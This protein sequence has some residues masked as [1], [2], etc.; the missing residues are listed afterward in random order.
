MIEG[1]LSLRWTR[2]CRFTSSSFLRKRPTEA[3]FLSALFK[4]LSSA[5]GG[6]QGHKQFFSGRTERYVRWRLVEDDV[7]R[8]SEPALK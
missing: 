6:R 4:R 1:Q 2:R 3:T 7:T 8:R 5:C